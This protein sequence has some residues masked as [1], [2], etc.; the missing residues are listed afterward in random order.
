LEGQVGV[1]PDCSWVIA[2]I[3][4]GTF[5]EPAKAN[6]GAV[7]PATTKTEMTVRF[8]NPEVLMV[9]SFLLSCSEKNLECGH[10]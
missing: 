4:S 10:F 8:K 2:L 7:I 6:A 1:Y 3:F 5:F 9:G